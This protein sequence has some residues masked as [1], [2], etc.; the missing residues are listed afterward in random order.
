[1][2]HY[3]VVSLKVKDEDV[4]AYG[5]KGTMHDSVFWIKAIL[6]DHE[7]IIRQLRGYIDPVS[8]KLGDVG[9]GDFIT[10]LMVAHEKM[11]WMLRAH[12]P[13]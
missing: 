1:L 9:T 2:G 12:K 6:T 3:P 4:S 8:N 7:T 5:Q 10:S 13:G 11:A